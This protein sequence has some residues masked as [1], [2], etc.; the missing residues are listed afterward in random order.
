ME[1]EISCTI[2]FRHTKALQHT[3]ARARGEHLCT[4]DNGGSH[5]PLE[6]ADYAA[7]MHRTGG[8]PRGGGEPGASVRSVAAFDRLQHSIGCG[9][10]PQVLC[11]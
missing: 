6:A 2:Q 11:D 4:R 1:V 10:G 3:K 7:C 8:E 9:A 5:P